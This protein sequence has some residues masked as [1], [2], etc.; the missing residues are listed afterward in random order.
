MEQYSHAGG[1]Q[2]FGATDQGI[3]SEEQ[4]R[5][6]ALAGAAQVLVV[7][8]SRVT[9]WQALVPNLD[10]NAELLLLDAHR[11]GLTQIAAALA[12]KSGY[13]AIHVV[14][15]GAEGK[16]LLGSSWL[17]TAGLTDHA[18][19]LAT[20]GGALGA[21]GD[22][23]LYGCDIAAG[24]N[25]ADFLAAF[26]AATGADVSAST[27]DTGA[28]SLGGDWVLEASTGSIEA[29][30][31]VSAEAQEAYDGLLA[32]S[33]AA[34]TTTT[35]TNDVDGD[36]VADPGDTVHHVVRITNSGST[37]A[38]GVTLN[39]PANL[40]TVSGASV[41]VTPIALDDAFSMTGNTP[42]TFTA[43]QLLGNDIDPDGPEANLAIVSV[44][45]GSNGTVVNNG[46]GT[47][48]FT[49]TT[50]LAVGATATFTY[51][52]RDEQNLTNVT[53]YNGVVTLTI[54]DRVWYVDDS[55]GGGDSDGSYGKPFTSLAQL[56]GVTGDGSTN[57]DVDGANDTIFVAAGTYTGGIVLEAG[58]K[59]IGADHAFSANGVTISDGT[60]TTVINYSGQGVALAQNNTIQGLTLNGT[61]ANAVGIEDGNGTVGTLTISETSI[62]GTGKAFDVDQGGTLDVTLNSL[63]SSGSASEG[64]HL[65]GVSGSFT[66]NGGTIQTAVGRGFLIGAAGGGTAS[67]G[68]A[69]TI[70]YG[71]DLTN[72][73]GAATAG[74]EIQDR[75]GGTVTFG[76]QIAENT[77]P[78]ILADQS[79]GTINFNG[80]VSINSGTATGVSLTNNSAA[81]NFAPTGDGLDLTTSSGTAL[82]MSNNSGAV[83]ITGVN[84]SITTDSGNLVSA[85]NAFVGAGGLS[86]GAL[87]VNSAANTPFSINNL[88]GIGSVSV[89]S[90]AING[91]GDSVSGTGILIQ[92]SD[93]NFTFTGAV[94]ITATGTGRGVYLDN[95]DGGTVTFSGG[96]NG[97]DIITAGGAGFSA[98]NG[99]TIVVTGS[100]NTVNSGNGTAV[101][102]SDTTI[103]AAD[104]TFQQVNS[105]GGTANGIILSNTGTS[106]G[107]HVTGNNANVG[108]TGGGVI[109][110]KTGA[111][112]SAA[113]QGTGIYLNNTFDV[114]L[115]GLL[116]QNMSNYGVYGLNVNSV[117]LTNSTFSGTF[118]DNTASADAPI[119]F[120]IIGGTNGLS[121]NSLFS[122]IDV[123][124]GVEHNIE[125]YNSSGSF[126]LTVL[127]SRIHDNSTA[128][129]SDGFLLELQG[130][131]DADVS[132]T[133]TTFQNNR[134]Q[135][136]QAA[137]NTNS[138]LDLTFTGNTITRGTQGNEGI[139]FTN[140]GD[141]DLRTLI[142][143][144]TISGFGG[145]SIFVGQTPGNA[146]A[147]SLLEAT[148]ASNTVSTDATDTGQI[149]NH[150]II[151]YLSATTGQV[152][153]A[154]LLIQGNT[155]NQAGD[156]ERAILVDTPDATRTPNFHAT[157]LNNI[158]NATNANAVTQISIAARNTAT[159]F[160]DVRGNDVNLPAGNGSIALNV[161]EAA[162]GNISLARGNSAAATAL[163]VLDQNHTDASTTTTVAGTV[164]VV[165]NATILLPS[166]P[167]TPTVPL[168]SEAPASQGAPT[169]V[170]TG[171]PT[172]PATGD[173]GTPA[174]TAPEPT[175]GPTTS[176]PSHPVIVED[177]V[178]SQAELDWFVAAAIARWTA[179]GATEAQVAAMRATHF[180][181]VDM[182]GVY[183]GGAQGDQVQI[184]SDGANFGWYLD[185]TPGDDAEFA[186]SGTRL[187]ATGAA[188]GKI[189]LL[190]A[191]LHE[192]GHRAGLHDSYAVGDRNELMYG[193]ITPGERRLPAYGEAAG[194]TANGV[195]EGTHFALAPV[196]IGLLPSN[197]AVEIHYD[198]LVDA[199]ANQVISNPVTST[200][201]VSGSNFGPVNSTPSSVTVDTLSI[202][203]TVFLDSDRDGI[204]DAGESGISGVAL[205]LFADAN[206]DDVADGAALLTTTTNASGNYTFASLGAGN[207]LVQVDASNFTGAGALV[208]RGP[209]VTGGD[210]DNDTDG[211]SNGGEL[212]SGV[213]RSQSIT[214][215]Y[216][217]EPTPGTGNDTNDTLDFGFIVPNQAP[218]FSDLT[219][220]VASFTEEGGTVLLDQGTASSVADSDSANFSGGQLIVSITS[221]EVA[222]EDVLGI[223]TAGTVTLSDGTQE[224]SI[225]SVG[226]TPVG[227]IQVSGTG[228]GGQDLRVDLNA[229]ATATTITTLIRALTYRN[230]NTTTPDSTDRVVTVTLI[231]GDGTVGGGN[232]TG[233][234]VTTVTVTPVDDAPV[235]V[236]DTPASFAENTTSALDLTTNDTDVDGGTRFVAELNGQAAVVDSWIALNSGARVKLN[237][238]G[239]VT[240]DPNGKFDWL[241]DSTSGATNTSATDSFTYK[242]NGGSEGTASVTINGV[243][244]MGDE[245]RGDATDNDITGTSGAD[246]FMLDGGGEDSASGGD[247]SDGFFLGSAFDGG[248][249]IDGGAGADD[250]LALRGVYDLT[251]SSG[252]MSDVET[253]VLLSGADTRFGGPTGQTYSYTLST[254]DDVVGTGGKLIVSGNGL[255]ANESFTFIGSGETNGVFTFFAGA[256]AEDLTGGQGN[257]GFFFGSSMF[258]AATDKVN[259]FAGTD[260]QMALRGDYSGGNALNFGAASMANIDTLTLLSSADT[261]FGNG[262]GPFNYAITMHDGNVAAGEKLVVSATGLQ[263]NEG[264]VFDG[265]AEQ[266][267]FFDLRG[268]GG[269]DTIRGGE[270]NDRIFGGVGADMLAGG[271][272]A[273]GDGDGNDVF[274]YR[275]TG[276]TTTLSPDSIEFFNTGDKIDLGV[277]DANTAAG[278]DQAFTVIG[279]GA[280]TGVA[281]QL[282]VTNLVG[283]DWEVR[284]DTDGDGNADLLIFLTSDHAL[285]AADFFL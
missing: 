8:D 131:A 210:P 73:G 43:A 96:G 16:T 207:Y 25:G 142:S 56:N 166:T 77:G 79:A 69:A 90:L 177:G 266:D 259:G 160:A 47:F 153:Q 193:Y 67:S 134:S 152:S 84:N 111:D 247:G 34:T 78:G 45:A 181:V 220:D 4:I 178:L 174:G 124:G 183:L 216:N 37:D 228:T 98:V 246:M 262:T 185:T 176:A 107:F 6:T 63:S 120:G 39:D 165:E 218:V 212:V 27:D 5:T 143:G 14:A 76:G 190:T 114:Q 275:S 85:V 224:G 233:S 103:G 192:L 249:A 194:A 237:G 221:G 100:S 241:T 219:N 154:R 163:D 31:I 71:G 203:S 225:V 135:A 267:G 3:A 86:L 146:T 94:G 274:V 184:D 75:T 15:H 158:A 66:A 64:V 281:G 245:L 179:A 50:G 108:A 29:E 122:N 104:V 254:D 125:V 244:G 12:G 28:A 209:S 196:S 138:T 187:T 41:Q 36:G 272:T 2:Q 243:A 168:L 97:L 32:V 265:S 88:D 182:A 13:A 139:L 213:V 126:D 46:N 87:T 202:A 70:S 102:I 226:G 74:I 51:Q 280:F 222:A 129:G 155:V 269:V 271:S 17:D 149:L 121:G 252:M 81:I 240:Y 30:V 250:Q 148:I 65:Q 133:G 57:D 167:D 217:T 72:N 195:A 257:D 68:G 60:G 236:A 270:G 201:V 144:N 164:P 132:V 279:S 151:A 115:N 208:G 52:V 109:G 251:I 55:Y 162:G 261:R 171:E 95:N 234:A 189:D 239:T 99:G 215:A 169:S 48:T 58:Q 157:V 204:L 231:D 83:T 141:S 276:E 277:I 116:V 127:N 110:S 191:V 159:G 1:E 117:Q 258:N 62:G 101:N 145:T 44:S 238:D 105:S 175:T 9:D 42:I 40:G 136:M 53:G 278:G 214:L 253:L 172:Q 130:N 21:D 35:L 205:S 283:Q 232:D 19:A 123:S 268:G 248:D 200:P 118:G 211:D 61:G 197:K 93:T 112:A 119:A 38:T 113:T 206:D 54:T 284:G 242:L 235:A 150:A 23:L 128:T 170:L 264:L 10:G 80:R 180:N 255:Q 89:G 7:V 173:G 230:T 11:D 223:S 91:I 273:D 106:G 24:E 137:A 59:L 22:I 256:G 20:I 282:Q 227:T 26:A 147:N 263:A 156:S 49:P 33:V 260:D 199:Y 229:S 198:V 140:G 285:T 92:G 186:G 18:D 161:R 188:V 82:S